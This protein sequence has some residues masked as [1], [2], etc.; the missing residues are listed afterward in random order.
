MYC[1]TYSPF[2]TDLERVFKASLSMEEFLQ[3]KCGTVIDMIDRGFL[4][5]CLA[6]LVYAPDQLQEVSDLSYR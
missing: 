5:R 6:T 1:S 3:G 4:G 2:L